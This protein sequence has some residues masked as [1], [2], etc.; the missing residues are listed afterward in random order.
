[1]DEEA[2]FYRWERQGGHMVQ[3]YAPIDIKTYFNRETGNH[4]VQKWDTIHTEAYFI[5]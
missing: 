5:R 1:M 4:N 2:Y 3:N